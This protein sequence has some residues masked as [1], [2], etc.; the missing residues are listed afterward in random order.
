MAVT[1]SQ[2]RKRPISERTGFI[3]ETRQPT[4][5]QTTSA[6]LTGAVD[7]RE[8]AER[9]LMELVLPW[10]PKE[11]TPNFKRSN[12]WTKYRKHIKAY[13][14]QCGWIARTYYKPW[15]KIESLEFTVQFNPPDRRK[16]DHDGMIGGFKAGIDG[17]A[18][19]FGC[20]DNIFRITYVFG[21]PVKNGKVTIIFD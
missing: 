13:R 5:E 1:K 11:L 7:T 3:V 9:V 4:R 21:E 14:E 20:D 15:H 16:R 10:P 18:D 2:C 19:A 17:L 12:H 6:G 8:Q